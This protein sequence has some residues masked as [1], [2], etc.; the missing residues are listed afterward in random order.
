MCGQTHVDAR[1]DP[2]RMTPSVPPHLKPARRVLLVFEPPYGGV[3]EAVG[4]LALLLPQLGWQVEVAGPA[5]SGVY[6]A[7][8]RAGVKVHR[9]PLERSNGRRS[10]Y[11][12]ALARLA[13]LLSSGRFS[14]V[15]AH[16]SKAGVL[17][18]IAAR[19]TGTPVV[20]SPH[21]YA[22]V[23]P[24]PRTRRL[25]ALTVERAMRRVTTATVCVCEDEQRVA[26][27]HGVASPGRTPVIYNGTLPCR[28]DVDADEG[29]ARLRGDGV[30]AAAVAEL[31]GEQ[32]G[33]DVLLEAAP[34]VLATLPDARVAIVGNGPTE[35]ALRAR[36]AQLG[37][38]GH[39]RFALLPFRAPSA[40]HLQTI[41]VF[42]LPSRWEAFPIGI[43]EALA[44]GVP[45]VCSDV[46][47]VGEAVDARTG[48]LVPPDDAAALA[49]A[50]IELLGDPAL[51]RSMSAASMHRHAERY[52]VERMAAATAALYD[53]LG[54]A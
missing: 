22:F 47:G 15:H 27:R 21:C 9:L 35:R 18:R 32:K 28:S 2:R 53:D 25:F 12:A 36:A 14:L 8:D 4:Q 44:C 29:T 30:L 3:P 13:G 51:R 34:R 46:G 31:R 6:P 33:L 19:L 42:V 37:V 48:R 17:G 40:S 7:L 11:A 24:V 10:R 23:G 26:Y 45:Q 50:I 43:L 5:D 39:P 1:S 38:L 41:D 49:D 20:Y 52:K 54:T 16:S